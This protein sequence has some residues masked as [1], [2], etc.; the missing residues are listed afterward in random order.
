MMMYKGINLLYQ[1]GIFNDGIREWGRQ[2]T[3]QKTWDKYELLF[4]R[5]QQEQRGAVTTAGKGGYTATV[6]NVYGAPPPPPE[7][8]YEAI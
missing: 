1:T 3:D 8:H 7:E 2:T 6:Q 5:Y 4:H